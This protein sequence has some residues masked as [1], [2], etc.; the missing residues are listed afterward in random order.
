VVETGKGDDFSM[1][2]IFT[3]EIMHCGSFSVAKETAVTGTCPPVPLSNTILPVMIGL[4]RFNQ[5]FSNSH[6]SFAFDLRTISIF[7]IPV[8]TNMWLTV[9]C[10]SPIRHDIFSLKYTINVWRS[11]SVRTR[12][13]AHSAL[14][15]LDL[16]SGA[17]GGRRKESE[18][19][20]RKERESG[21]A[22]EE[23]PHFCK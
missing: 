9:D 3:V 6:K 23:T 22:R 5:I 20:R 15:S 10:V 1:G 13:G 11:D 12:W 4:P 8:V 21:T 14:P 19:G 18:G 2:R 7:R 17:P 16:G